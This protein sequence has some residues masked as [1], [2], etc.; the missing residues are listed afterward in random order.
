MLLEGLTPEDRLAYLNQANNY[1]TTP[2]HIAAK[3]GHVNVIDVLLEG[4]TPEDRLAYL[5]KANKTGYSP[6]SVAIKYKHQNIITTLQAYGAKDSWYQKFLR[7]ND[8]LNAI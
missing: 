7:F 1:G 4:L 2:L 6:L 3:N 8:L 5:N